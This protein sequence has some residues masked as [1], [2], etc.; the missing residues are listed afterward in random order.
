[1][2]TLHQSANGTWVLHPWC[3][4]RSLDE[5]GDEQNQGRYCIAYSRDGWFLLDTETW[6]VLRWGVSEADVVAARE[7]LF[8]A[9]S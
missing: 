9:Q 3:L 5:H 1:M 6:A 8:E 2:G 4:P 7:A